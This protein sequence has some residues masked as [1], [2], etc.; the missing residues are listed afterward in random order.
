MCIFDDFPSPD[1]R[2]YSDIQLHR[3]GKVRRYSGYARWGYLS[4][5]IALNDSEGAI[6]T[7]AAYS[8]QSAAT[9]KECRE[10]AVCRMPMSNWQRAAPA[11]LPATCG[12]GCD[13]H[14]QGAPCAAEVWRRLY[15][16]LAILNIGRYM[17]T[18]RPPIIPPRKT[19][20]KGSIM[21]VRFS[22]AWS[23]SSS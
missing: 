23:T 18:T 17:A 20:M 7:A 6:H 2:I 12:C 4:L 5:R 16:T 19:I 21:A 3:K 1:K 14:G 22:T 8:L 11:V 15:T 9:G 13:D 10:G